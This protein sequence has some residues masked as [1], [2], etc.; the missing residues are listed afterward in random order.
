METRRSAETPELL[1]NGLVPVQ[2]FIARAIPLPPGTA[3]KPRPDRPADEELE[4]IATKD[5]RGNGKQGQQV[6]GET[7][8][9]EGT[10]RE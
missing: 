5:A 2:S 10:G 8:S 9:E 1:T 4:G 3:A 6:S 7:V